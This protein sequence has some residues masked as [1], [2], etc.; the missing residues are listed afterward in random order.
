LNA[1]YLKPNKYAF[2]LKEKS[3]QFF[4]NLMGKHWKESM[5]Q[6]DFVTYFYPLC[7]NEKIVIILAQKLTHLFILQVIEKL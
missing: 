6:S 2:K 3:V 7:E 4:K 5:D 1:S